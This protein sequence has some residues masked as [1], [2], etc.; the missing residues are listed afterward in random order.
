MWYE[1][2]TNKTTS[3][4]NQKENRILYSLSPN[5]FANFLIIEKEFSNNDKLF[6]LSLFDVTGRQVQ[7]TT[8]KDITQQISTTHLANGLYFYQVINAEGQ[9]IA[10]GKVIKH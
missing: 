10:N 4:N 3:I 7:T 8:L 1:N 6:Q 5:P 9:V 2:L